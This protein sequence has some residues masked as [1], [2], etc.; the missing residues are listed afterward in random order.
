MILITYADNQRRMVDIEPLL[1][2]K[3][4]EKA[5]QLLA[6]DYFKRVRISEAGETIEWENGY[7]ICPDNLYEI[8]KD[9][10]SKSA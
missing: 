7:D 6:H 10:A 9:V 5:Q 8:G 4:G 2:N 1:R 3:K